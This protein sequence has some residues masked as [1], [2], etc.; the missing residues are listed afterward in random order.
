VQYRTIEAHTNYAMRSTMADYKTFNTS[1][2]NQ[3]Y[4]LTFYLFLVL[5]PDLLSY[6]IYD[7]YYRVTWPEL[8]F[9]IFALRLMGA[10]L[11]LLSVLDYYTLFGNVLSFNGGS[12]QKPICFYKEFIGSRLLIEKFEKNAITPVGNLVNTASSHRLPALALYD[13]FLGREK[14]KWINM[15][16]LTKN[17]ILVILA[18]SRGDNTYFRLSLLLT[19]QLLYIC[20]LVRVIWTNDCKFYG[21]K[22]ASFDTILN[23]LIFV[24]IFGI[25][26]IFIGY[27]DTQ[28]MSQA[29]YDGLSTGTIVV[30]TIFLCKQ[31]LIM[32][33]IFW[34]DFVGGILVKMCGKLFTE[35]YNSKIYGHQDRLDT[36]SA[37]KMNG[38]NF[39]MGADD[40]AQRVGDVE[41]EV[42]VEERVYEMKVTITR[43]RLSNRAGSLS[44]GFESTSRQSEKFQKEFNPSDPGDLG[45]PLDENF[46]FFM[47]EQGMN[48]DVAK[49]PDGIIGGSL[50]P[51][52]PKSIQSESICRVNRQSRQTELKQSPSQENFDKP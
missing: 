45:F 10:L 43:Q 47:K 2:K 30:Q 40:G 19:T 44:G 4:K 16:S 49:N 52:Y 20:Y 48:L 9:G 22:L 31:V 7:L 18:V 23:E 46:D 50:A 6:G 11:V 39:E 28:G 21:T 5:C 35:N 14:L 33:K 24:F 25:L 15:A 3:V 36:E 17:L 51:S 26:I 34:V 37:Q 32:T 1:V 12:F 29:N 41:V 42:E 13:K 38:T 27:A 8:D